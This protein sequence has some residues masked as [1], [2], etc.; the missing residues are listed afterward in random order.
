MLSF[1]AAFLLALAG[2]V[3]RSLKEIIP[4]EQDVYPNN[5]HRFRPIRKILILIPLVGLAIIG[6]LF[7]IMAIT[8]FGFV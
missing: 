7:G 5:P 6:V 2:V 8:C 4:E 3:Y 1:L